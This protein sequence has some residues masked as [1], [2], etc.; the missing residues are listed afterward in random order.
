M[1]DAHG[2]ERV[3]SLRTSA[4]EANRTDPLFNSEYWI[5]KETFGDIIQFEE[6]ALE[7]CVW[8]VK[9]GETYCI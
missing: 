7:V 1:N 6:T 3:T 5:P 8:R 2:E 4:W 9:Y